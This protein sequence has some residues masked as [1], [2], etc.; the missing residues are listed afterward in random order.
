M[1]P[2]A[3]E[4]SVRV[5]FDFF[6]VKNH[7]KLG[8]ELHGSGPFFLKPRGAPGKYVISLPPRTPGS[9]WE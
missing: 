2:C 9:Q 8:L 7:K 6:Q 3:R 5:R 1:M 4:K